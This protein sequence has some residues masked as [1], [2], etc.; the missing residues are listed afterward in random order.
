MQSFS[1]MSQNAMF[2]EWLKTRDWETTIVKK[3][4]VVTA[5]DKTRDK[6]KMVSFVGLKRE[7]GKAGAI[8]H[9]ALAKQRGLEGLWVETRSRGMIG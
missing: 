9:R 6:T 4:K 3:G 5:S 8:K 2:Q 1:N 7:M